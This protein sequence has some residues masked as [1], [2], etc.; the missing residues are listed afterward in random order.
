MLRM[1]RFCRLVRLKYSH[2][3]W[4]R[5]EMPCYVI[6]ESSLFSNVFFDQW[7]IGKLVRDRRCILIRYLALRCSSRNDGNVYYEVHRE[8]WNL[9]LRREAR[10][11]IALANARY[12]LDECAYLRGV[13]KI[14]VEILERVVLSYK[15]NKKILLVR[16]FMELPRLENPCYI[17]NTLYKECKWM[18][19]LILKNFDESCEFLSKYLIMFGKLKISITRWSFLLSRL[20][21]LDICHFLYGWTLC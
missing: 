9:K 8:V 10:H 14:G 15:V 21:S 4:W 5:V 1:G 16:E 19:C 7:I 3:S 2:Y 13:Q 17:E 12:V 18:T 20:N 6:N 11:L